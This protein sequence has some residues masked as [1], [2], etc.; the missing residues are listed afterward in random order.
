MGISAF[1]QVRDCGS[2][3]SSRIGINYH[4]LNRVEKRKPERFF[5]SLRWKTSGR[6][7]DPWESRE[8][9]DPG[10]HAQR[11]DL[12]RGAPQSSAT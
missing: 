6:S 12:S 1:I 3:E 8:T 11:K 10:R 9:R 7:A 2:R 5:E 4:V